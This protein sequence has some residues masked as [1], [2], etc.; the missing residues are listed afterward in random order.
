MEYSYYFGFFPELGLSISQLLFLIVI[1]LFITFGFI[2]YVSY[3][4]DTNYKRIL[5]L[6]SYNFLWFLIGGLVSGILMLLIGA[7]IYVLI[8][9]FAGDYS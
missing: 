6:L 4:I 7:I 9:E 2:S 3:K 8:R 1:I 5:Y